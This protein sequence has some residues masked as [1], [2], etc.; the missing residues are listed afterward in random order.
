MPESFP[1]ATRL[2][3]GAVS[4]PLYTKMTQ[5]DQE[6]VIDAVTSVLEGGC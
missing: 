3:R 4:L 2:Y 5:T 1:E 6:R